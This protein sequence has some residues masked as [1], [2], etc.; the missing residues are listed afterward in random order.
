VFNNYWNFIGTSLPSGWTSSSSTYIQVNNG[1]YLN[2]TD[3]TGVTNY[4]YYGTAIPTPYI[5]EGDLVKLINNKGAPAIGISE[6]SSIS[7]GYNY[8]LSGGYGLWFTSTNG[9][10]FINSAGTTINGLPALSIP[11]ITSLIWYKTGGENVSYNYVVKASSS[12]SSYSLGSNMYIDVGQSAGSYYTSGEYQWLRVRDYPPGGVMPSATPICLF[13]STPE[14]CFSWTSSVYPKQISGATSS[15]LSIP[16][17]TAG[18]F[19]YYVNVNDSIGKSVS[20]NNGTYEVKYVYTP[21][22]VSISPLSANYYVGQNIN[23]S[24]AASGGTPPYSY[25]WYNDT[26]TQTAIS[27]ATSSTYSTPANAIGTYKYNVQVTDKEPSTISSATGTYNI[28]QPLG[29]PTLNI[30]NSFYGGIGWCLDT[31][32][33]EG[34]ITIK[35]NVQGGTGDIYYYFYEAY[36]PGSPESL[37]QASTSNNYTFNLA[38]KPDGDYEFQVQVCD[39][40]DYY[41][42]V[43][44]WSSP[45]YVNTILTWCGT[46]KNPSLSSSILT[47]SSIIIQN[48]YTLNTNCYDLISNGN[49]SLFGNITT[50]YYGGN[51]NYAYNYYYSPKGQF[52]FSGSYALN[53]YI[54][55]GVFAGAG[56]GG[57]GG[58]AEVPS[59]ETLDILSGG[60]GAGSGGWGGPGEAYN[61]SGYSVDG[62]CSTSSGECMVESSTSAPPGGAGGSD[63]TIYNIIGPIGGIG[64]TNESNIY[65]GSN[66]GNGG[67]TGSGTINNTILQ[68]LWNSNEGIMGGLAGAQGGQGG[69]GAF[70]MGGFNATGGAG[71]LG[72][73][74]LYIQANNAI[75]DGYIFANGKNGTLGTGNCYSGVGAAVGGGGGGGGGGGIIIAFNTTQSP[76]Y[77][78][79]LFENKGGYG[80]PQNTYSGC[81]YTLYGGAGG[82]GGYG[83]SS[84]YNYPSGNPPIKP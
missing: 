21:L 60:G 8:L 2:P 14:V 13:S 52:N 5:V 78:T 62:I 75:I 59:G 83:A 67:N 80:A 72:A 71:G 23:I 49:V 26:G 16:L 74:G 44:K 64:G 46:N 82:G 22:S 7:E 48:G 6:G 3:T 54:F 50:G 39:Y 34:A 15:K 58:T 66:G 47:N 20:S 4:A 31:N 61:G 12:D 18:N 37:V 27:G 81:G 51:G 25:Q 53:P 57:G 19:S 29:V 56:G 73:C 10:Q 43:C 63:Q 69:I 36:P 40:G 84:Y 77:H 79:S 33:S 1:L 70:S 17:T 41:G 38:G 68:S 35:A 76:P 9:G 42:G 11:V 28:Y 55:G 30:T 45:L 65:Y 24:S 32:T